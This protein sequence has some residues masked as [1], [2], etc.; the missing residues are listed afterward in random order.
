MN[1]GVN[2]FGP[3]E[4]QDS[5]GRVA[6]LNIECLKAG[7][8]N[9]DV[10]RLPR[11]RPNETVEYATLND[12][13]ISSLQHRINLFHFNAR[14]VPLYFSRLGEDSLK[15]FYNIGFW[16]HEMQDIPSHWA[17]Q[18]EF[19]NE[20]WTPSSLSQNAVSQSSNIPVLRF[21]YPIEEKPLSTRMRSIAD[22]KSFSEFNF[23]SVFDV[24]SDAERKNPL[25]VIRAF[26]NAHQNN[27]NVRLIVKTRN[28]AQ[29]SSLSE[30]F[31]RIAMQ[32]KNVK[33]IDGY[34]DPSDLHELYK[35]TDA[36][37][38]LHRAEGFGLTISDA[39]SCGIP[40]IVTGYSGN[41]DFCNSDARLVAYSLSKVGH[42]R[43]R[44][45]HN[46][47]WAEPDLDDA[48]EA[49]SELVTD[50]KKWVQRAARA[51]LRLQREFSIA[52]IGAQMRKRVDLIRNNFS[53]VNDMDDR[54][55]DFQ[56]GISNHYGF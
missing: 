32:Y 17:R 51:R 11:P 24:Y 27:H 22:G 7:N 46:D 30:I 10:Y 36:Y 16:V 23:L 33:F 26:L 9:H 37:A 12:E 53:F 43:P 19:F 2:F 21:S 49:F 25:F 13:L 54:K 34:I 29:D 6:S 41:M 4:A 44:Y 35:N 31:S 8:I 15:E 55:I 14:R 38:S 40:V 5:I 1:N 39:M 56:V 52:E 45:R 48:T 20:I 47:V 18:L 28:L 42:N 3:Y 50:H